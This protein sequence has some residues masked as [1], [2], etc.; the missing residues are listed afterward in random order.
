MVISGLALPHCCGASHARRC[1]RAGARNTFGLYLH[2]HANAAQ[3][4]ARSRIEI[5]QARLLV[6]KT[7]WMIGQVGANG[8]AKVVEVINHRGVGARRA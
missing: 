1:E 5:D 3:R 4:I 6:R 7:A 8:P 2:A